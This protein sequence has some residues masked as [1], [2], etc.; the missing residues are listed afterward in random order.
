[1]L[2]AV[3]ERRS[4]AGRGRSRLGSVPAPSAT[5]PATGCYQIGVRPRESVDEDVIAETAT[6]RTHR[7]GHR[8][9]DRI[10]EAGMEDRKREGYF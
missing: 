3:H 6:S 7:R 1:M 10:S 5:S 2:L 9:D 8:S 4:P